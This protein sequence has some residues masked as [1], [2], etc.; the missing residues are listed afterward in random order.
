MLVWVVSMSMRMQVNKRQIKIKNRPDY[1]FNDNM[2]VNIKDFDSS[3]LEIKKLPFKGVFNLN[4]YDIKYIPTKST[5]RPSIDTTDNDEDFL[6][7]FLDDVER[8]I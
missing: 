2:I 5:N 8:H 7:L 3:V 1:L 6:Y 4:I